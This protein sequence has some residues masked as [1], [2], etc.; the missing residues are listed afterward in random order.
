MASGDGQFD[1]RLVRL[2]IQKIIPFPVDSYIQLSNGDKGYVIH[3]HE[4]FLTRPK[5]RIVKQNDIEIPPF[6]I[7]LI[8]DCNLSNLTIIKFADV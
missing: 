3:N 8:G 6:I 5:I 2:F 1:S 4:G 7:D